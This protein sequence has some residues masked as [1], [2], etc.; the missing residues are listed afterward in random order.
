[1]FMLSVVGLAQNKYVGSKFC[2]ACH[3]GGKGGNAYTVWEKS[4][5]ANAYKTLAGE[6]AKKIAKSK[7]LK[8]A[9][10]ENEACLKCH[11]TGGGKAKNVEVSFKKTEGVGCEACHG[12]ASGYKM[13]HSKGDGAKSKAA[14]LII[15]EK[16]EKG[17]VTCHNAESPTRKDFKFDEMWVKIAHGKSAKK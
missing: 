9:P 10:A 2:A 12:A 16:N 14:G 15:P 1:M 7:G 17:C 3:K 13:I 6:A 5:H 8:T 4:A 11:V